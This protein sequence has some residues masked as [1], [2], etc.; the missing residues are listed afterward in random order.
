MTMSMYKAIRETW[1]KGETKKSN[2]IA[3]RRQKTIE[4]IER[5]TRLDRARALG[6]K[7]KQGY[8]LARVHIRKGARRRREFGRKGRKP[9]K[10]GLVK[11]RP[12]SLRWIAE[13]RVQKRFVNMVVLNS[14]LAG[15]DGP[16]K[17]FEVIL[18]DPCSP[19]IKNDPKI[20]WICEKRNIR[21]TF[22]GLTGAGKKARGLG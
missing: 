1:K 3:W 20:N 8:V 9:S 19:H 18:V 11:F 4:R 14:Y 2:L 12:K 6:Y 15:E 13:D 7:A 21:R 5:P 22:H 16:T 10:L 17:F